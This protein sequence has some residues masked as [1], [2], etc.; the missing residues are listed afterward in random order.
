MSKILQTGLSKREGGEL[1]S[2]LLSPLTAVIAALAGQTEQ[3]ALADPPWI[4]TSWLRVC[5]RER[6]SK[7]CVTGTP[8]FS[9]Q[10]SPH[11]PSS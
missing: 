3:A 8:L 4:C 7:S 9:D 1:F 2:Q 11:L 5:C 6:G 10:I